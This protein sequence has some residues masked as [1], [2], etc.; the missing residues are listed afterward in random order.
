[1][2]S[3]QPCSRTSHNWRKSTRCCWRPAAKSYH[4]P[5]F[6]YL[7][8]L[9]LFRTTS[10]FMGLP[11]SSIFFAQAEPDDHIT[12]DL[13]FGLRP[14]PNFNRMQ[15][16]SRLAFQLC[17]KCRD[18]TKKLVK[19]GKC[20][21]QKKRRKCKAKFKGCLKPRNPGR[22]QRIARLF[23]QHCDNRLLVKKPM[24][25]VFLHSNR[26][27]QG[28]SRFDYRKM[29]LRDWCP[30]PNLKARRNNGGGGGPIARDNCGREV[31]YFAEFEVELDL[32]CPVNALGQPEQPQNERDLMEAG[33]LEYLNTESACENIVENQGDECEQ[34]IFETSTIIEVIVGEDC[35][36]FY[37]SQGIPFPA[38]RLLGADTSESETN[39]RGL[40]RRRKTRVKKRT[41]GRCRTRK[42]KCRRKKKRRFLRASFDTERGF[43]SLSEKNKIESPSIFAVDARGLQT[44]VP[45]PSPVECAQNTITESIVSQEPILFRQIVDDEEISF[46]E[47]IPCG[48]L[49]DECVSSF[50]CCRT[51]GCK[52]DVGSET[53][54]NAGTIFGE[55]VN[56]CYLNKNGLPGTISSIEDNLCCD[57][58][59]GPPIAYRYECAEGICDPLPVAICSSQEWIVPE[60]RSPREGTFR[61]DIF[62][63]IF[64]ICPETLSNT[65][66]AQSLLQSTMEQFFRNAIQFAGCNAFVQVT[67][68]QILS[69]DTSGCGVGGSQF[70]LNPN[71]GQGE[72]CVGVKAR[73][74]GTY[75]K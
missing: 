48:R 60:P 40:Q 23:E 51:A 10:T 36:P 42:K 44:T 68:V 16:C 6:A 37:E 2:T 70:C 64:D 41:S 14:R 74:D 73:I 3:K 28:R 22:R 53:S 45:L 35:R 75:T 15:Y 9:L 65:I 34:I 19:K 59:P 55:E 47:D 20:S 71:N 72:P 66:N 17:N 38:R 61:I 4:V 24:Q 27:R 58:D 43:I 63:D 31:E 5:F 18:S 11:S 56:Q 30:I 39:H 25:N 21:P 54:C 52:C 67:T 62:I 49:S 46:E 29:L 26:G 50:R 12:R 7:L 57:I 33:L 13:Q 8:C 1:M 69:T 32:Y